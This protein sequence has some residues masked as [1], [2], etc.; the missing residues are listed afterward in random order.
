MALRNGSEKEQTELVPG[1]YR[2]EF[3]DEGAVTDFVYVP[4]V[5]KE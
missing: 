5:V 3:N 1:L 4:F 2:F